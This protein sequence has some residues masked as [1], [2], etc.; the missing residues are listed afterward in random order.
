MANTRC[1]CTCGVRSHT[2]SFPPKYYTYREHRSCRDTFIRGRT[3]TND[4]VVIRMLRS[5]NKIAL[6]CLRSMSLQPPDRQRR[7]SRSRLNLTGDYISLDIDRACT[8]TACH[9]CKFIKNDYFFDISINSS[10]FSH[11]LNRNGRAASNQ[12]PDILQYRVSDTAICIKFI[13]RYKRGSL[14]ITS[15]GSK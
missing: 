10:V 3:V 9:I 11:L 14:R 6:R 13:S 2:T 7:T 1:W 12:T 5:E 8:S 4:T 15:N